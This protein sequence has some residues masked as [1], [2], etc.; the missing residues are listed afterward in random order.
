MDD[1]ADVI[2]PE[3]RAGVDEPKL[4]Q[5][6]PGRCAR[7]RRDQYVDIDVR[8][9]LLGAIQRPLERRPLSSSP[10]TPA[11]SNALRTSAAVASSRP[12]ELGRC[13]A[14]RPM[15]SSSSLERSASESGS[16]FIWLCEAN[17][18]APM[19]GFTDDATPIRSRS[20]PSA[21]RCRSAPRPPRCWPRSSPTCR[22]LT[23]GR[24][25]APS[26]PDGHRRAGRRQL[27]VYD[28]ERPI[29]RAG[30]ASYGAGRPGL[31]DAH[32]RRDPCARERC[33]SM[34]GRWH[35][36]EARS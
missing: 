35:T 32:A 33:S 14:K 10:S 15:N 19:G 13:A 9:G 34:R 28:G 36:P 3:R 23:M 6:P 25:V 5:T 2:D 8:P 18:A 4:G 16:V 20:R 22:R 21:S 24:P 17:L 27:T 12:V 11:R 30:R 29:N 31:A 1:A 26:P 7:I